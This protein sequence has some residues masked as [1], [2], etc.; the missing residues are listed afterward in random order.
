M[1]MAPP[2]TIPAVFGTND[3][4]ARL[5]PGRGATRARTGSSTS[6]GSSASCSAAAGSPPLGANW[7]WAVNWYSGSAA[8]TCAPAA[9]LSDASVGVAAAVPKPSIS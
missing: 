6:G 2:A 8:A 5:A 9:T 4:S 3:S 1:S 7:L